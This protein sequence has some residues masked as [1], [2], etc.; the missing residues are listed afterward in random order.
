MGTSEE[1][2]GSCEARY[3]D[4]LAK[5]RLFFTRA[6][7]LILEA[8]LQRSDH[9]S[10]DDLLFEMQQ[11]GM[12]VSRATLYRSLAQMAAAGVLSEVDLGRG[13]IHYETVDHPDHEHL[14]CRSCNR[15]FE[16]ES[17][18]LTEAIR[19]LSEREGFTPSSIKLQIFGI[20]QECGSSKQKTR[21]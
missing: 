19:K 12:R 6:R 21:S 4:F 20:C 15:V 5:N 8:V 17:E 9:F 11:L 1:K 2:I 7:A 3:R 18:E 10:V 13:Q 16:T 14:I